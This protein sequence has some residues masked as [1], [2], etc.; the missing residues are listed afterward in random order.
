MVNNATDTIGLVDKE[1]LHLWVQKF[2]R[3]GYLFLPEILPKG[4]VPILRTDLDKAL[5]ENPAASGGSI[6][7]HPRMFERSPTNL[8][9]FGL[10]PIVSFAK[11]LIET[12]THVIHNNSFRT[13]PGGGLSTWH[14]DDPP[15]FL[16]TEGEPPKNIR[17]PV[18]LFTANYYLTDVDEVSHGPT[19]VIPGSHLFGKNPPN[20]MENS[21]YAREITSCLGKAGSV[22]MFN[23][24]VWHRGAP[25]TS[26]RTRYM[27]QISYA[28]R[29]IGHK[30]APFMNYNMPEHVYANADE[31]HLELLGFLPNGAYG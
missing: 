19:E 27:T 3:D 14:Q 15:H 6:E 22:V 7:L 11:A 16:V 28:R 20:G 12:T 25:N 4:W 21:S 5:S 18:L 23:N 24:Q 2:H 13:P 31:T 9:L 29:L 17:L 10:E 1:T 30:Y 26:K 8:S